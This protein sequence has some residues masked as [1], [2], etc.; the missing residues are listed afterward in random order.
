[1]SPFHDS[2]VVLFIYNSGLL[3]SGLLPLPS[4]GLLRKYP[5]EE[6]RQG[7]ARL[8]LASGLWLLVGMARKNPAPFNSF[9]PRSLA[10]MPEFPALVLWGLYFARSSHYF[11]SPVP[12]P[13]GHKSNDAS[14]SV[15]RQLKALENKEQK[16]GEN[17]KVRPY[18]LDHHLCLWRTGSAGSDSLTTAPRRELPPQCLKELHQ[19]SILDGGGHNDRISPKCYCED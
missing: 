1:M 19:A 14:A 8:E 11:L 2:R 6:G 12:L 5:T 13:G 10:Q 16:I 18:F 15:S 7:R 17:S 4:P 3:P 9:S